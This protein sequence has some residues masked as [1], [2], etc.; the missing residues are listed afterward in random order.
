MCESSLF[1]LCLID[2]DKK[3]FY[4]L[5]RQSIQI[6]TTDFTDEEVRRIIEELG[7]QFR[8]DKYH[9]M[10]NN[11]NHFSQGVTQVLI[12]IICVKVGQWNKNMTFSDCVRK[13]NSKLGESTGAIQLLRAIFAKVFTKVSLFR[14]FL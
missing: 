9:L 3:I 5:C 11:C 7:N 12:S 14:S 6:G 13:R 2:T 8:G 10:N 4:Q 1:L